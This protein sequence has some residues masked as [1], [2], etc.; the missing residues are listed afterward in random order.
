MRPEFIRSGTSDVGMVKMASSLSRDSVRRTSQIDIDGQMSEKIQSFEV[1]LARVDID[2]ILGGSVG[3]AKVDSLLENSKYQLFVAACTLVSVGL[4]AIETDINVAGV[5]RSVGVWV[6][7]NF[8]IAVF[9]I[10][11]V[12]RL[13]VYLLHFFSSS[14]NILEGGLLL[15]DVLLEFSTYFPEVDLPETLSVL[16]VMKILRFV[17]LARLLRSSA[18]TR[19]LFLMITGILASTR[20]LIFG[21]LLLLTTLT[22]FSILAVHFVRPVNRRLAEQG[23]LGDC[24]ICE[25]AFDTVLNANVYFL[26][27]IVAGDSWGRQSVPLIREDA[28][29]AIIM[30][31]A[32]LVTNLGL[33]NTIAAV[34]VDRQVQARVED[35]AFM[36]A[37]AS[38]EL[39]E[40]LKLLQT[41]FKQMD[42]SGDESIA[43]NELEDYYESNEVF[44]SILNQLDIHRPDLP[45][46]FKM[47]DK[48]NTGDVS[49]TEFVNGLHHIKNENMHTLMVFTRHYCE[50]I[51]TRLP[52]V[53][54]LLTHQTKHM[55]ARL[56]EVIRCVARLDKDTNMAAVSCPSCDST[57]IPTLV[58][59]VPGESDESA[60]KCMVKQIS[61]SSF[62]SSRKGV[63]RIGK[64]AAN[65]DV[66]GDSDKDKQAAS[67]HT[68]RPSVESSAHVELP[69][70]PTVVSTGDVKANGSS[71]RVQLLARSASCVVSART[72]PPAGLAACV[73]DL[74]PSSSTTLEPSTK[75]AP[76]CAVA[77]IADIASAGDEHFSASSFVG[78]KPPARSATCAAVSAPLS[79]VTAGINPVDVHHAQP[80]RLGN[81]THAP[82]GRRPPRPRRLQ[83]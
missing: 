43:L 5:E 12:F 42:E 2:E 66:S 80:Q 81:I 29:S 16:S 30:I 73:A 20:A 21:M 4:A 46:V 69:S 71:K 63:F 45:V 75:L 9:A 62:A 18:K 23:A 49:F 76:I 77:S 83:E 34:I 40:S 1:D 19:E 27:T 67:S 78:L 24:S 35:T 58:N 50:T 48:D 61:G 13:Y 28:A 32:L 7:G 79:V 37:V 38:D 47:L 44:R 22:V 74:S 82:V 36:A 17:R 41:I 65:P 70:P 52:D 60:R 6:T 8:V 64:V 72:T 14:L 53:G 56:R 57:E 33:L 3:R 10:D 54:K 15:I 25:D 26:T 51:F 39:R 55:D 59:D 31:G 11:V 68:S